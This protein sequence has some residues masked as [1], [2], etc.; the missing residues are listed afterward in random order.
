MAAITVAALVI[1]IFLFVLAYSLW[2][3]GRTVRQSTGLP[4]GRIVYED[5]DQGRPPEGPLISKQWRLVGKPDYLLESE[6]GLIPVEVK[7][8][9]L[10]RNGNPYWGHVLQ[11]AAYCLLVEEVYGQR[12]PHGYIRYRDKTV[13]VPYTDE[14]RNA[15][16]DTLVEVRMAMMAEGMARSHDDV[17]RCAHCGMAYVCGREKLIG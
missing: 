4:S 3:K 1:G 5:V 6:E 17:W 8:A 12:P 15:L 7:S 14:L 2:Q 16:L 9:N 13:R 10:P 11:L